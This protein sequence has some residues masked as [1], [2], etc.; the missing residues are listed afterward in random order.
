MNKLFKEQ[1]LN[2]ERIASEMLKS[3]EHIKNNSLAAQKIL[4]Q[5]NQVIIF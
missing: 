4:N 1:Q 3:V 2:Q 5:D